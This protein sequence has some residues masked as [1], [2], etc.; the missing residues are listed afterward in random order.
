MDSVGRIH[1]NNIPTPV[2]LLCF[3]HV[4]VDPIRTFSAS[5]FAFSAMPGVIF[6]CALFS[7]NL[8]DSSTDIS[9]TPLCGV[10]V[11]FDVELWSGNCDILFLL[12]KSE[13]WRKTRSHKMTKEKTIQIA[14]GG[15]IRTTQ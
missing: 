7:C 8:I 13:E 9:L 15:R 3:A 5:L 11:A 2:M 10:G 12:G 14:K 6:T 1:L 4:N